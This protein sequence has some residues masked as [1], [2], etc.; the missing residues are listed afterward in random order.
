MKNLYRTIRGLSLAMALLVLSTLH[1]SA[2]TTYSWSTNGS[3]NL[4]GTGTWDL[5][6][7]NWWTNGAPA[8]TWP[9]SGTDNLALFA[10]TAGTVTLGANVAANQLRFLTNG[11]TLSGAQTLTLNGTTPAIQVSGATNNATIGNNTALVLDGTA[12]LKKTGLG[13]LTLNGSAAHAFTGGLNVAQGTL[14]INLANLATPSNLIGS[15]NALTLGGGTLIVNGKTGAVATQTFASTSLNAGTSTIRAIN[16]GTSTTINLGNLTNNEP[17]AVVF[18]NGTGA[19]GTS[20]S[21]TERIFV[22]G[23]PTGAWL[24]PWA[25]TGNAADGTLRWAYL[26]ATS[27]GQVRQQAGITATATTMSNVVTNN[28]VYTATGTFTITNNVSALGIQA[29]G[30][31]TYNLGNFNMTIGGLT[32]LAAVASGT[33]AVQTSGSGQLRG[34]ANGNLITG[35]F[36]NSAINITAPIANYGVGT[37]TSL[38]HIGGGTL[39][40]GAVNPYSGRTTLNGGTLVVGSAST[41][42]SSSG[43]YIN[44]G[45]FRYNNTTTALTP[46]TTLNAGTLTGTGAVTLGAVTVAD[47]LGAIIANNNGAAGAALTT[48]NLSFNGAASL[49]LFLNSTNAALVSGALST[50]SAGQV[51]IT[52]VS[53]TGLWGTGLTY[54]LISYT[55]G[56]VG[57]AGFGQ[58]TLGTV[59]GTTSRQST[60]LGNT[61]L[62]ITMTINGD[63]PYWTG[64][65]NGNWNTTQTGNWKLLTAGTDTT[66]INGDEVIFN[67]NATGTTTVDITENVSTTSVTFSNNTQNYTI[68]SSGGFGITNAV[69]V[70]KNGSGT[71]TLSS[72]NT[73]AGGTAINNGTLRAQGG[74]AIGDTSVVTLADVSAAK[75]EVLNSETIGAL[76]GGGTSGGSV[77]VASGTTLTLSTSTQT[78]A[79][80]I[81]GAG[82]LTVSGTAVQTLTGSNTYTGATLINSGAR[83]NLGNGGT[84]GSLSPIGPITNNGTF[85]INR[86]GTTTQGVDFAN[87]LSGTGTL[88][89]LGG[90][91]VVLATNN[92]YNGTVSITNSAGTTLSLGGLNQTIGALSGG[93]STGGTVALGTNNLTIKALSNQ[94]YN[95]AFTGS[96]N[97][98]IDPGNTN[99]T[100]TFGSSAG[101][102]ST[103][104]TGNVQVR[105][106]TMILGKVNHIL[107]TNNSGLGNQSIFVSN[108]AT[109][110]LAYGNAAYPQYQ[111]FVLN[112]TG[113]NGQGALQALGM[114]FGNAGIGGIVAETDS[115]VRVTRDG[116]DAGTR[117]LLVNNAVA[118]SGNLTFDGGSGTR[119]GIVQLNV[120]SGALTLGGITYNAF[121]GNLTLTGNVTLI[122]NV[123]N[124]L[125]NVQKV[126]VLSGSTNTFNSAANQTI[127]G[128]EGGGTVNINGNTLTVGT[129]DASSTFA[130]VLQN[131]SGSGKLTKTGSGTFTLSASNSY[132]GNTTINGGTLALSGSGTIGSGN[133]VLNTGTLDISGTTTG[134]TIAATNSVTGSGAIVSTG[135]TFTLDGTLAPG[136]SPG[137]ITNTGDFNLGSTANTIME[138]AGSG[139]VAGVDFDY[140]NVTGQLSLGGSLLITNYNSFSL[141]TA[142]TYNLFDATTFSNNFASVAVGAISL[143]NSLGMWTGDNGV[144]TYSFSTLNGDLT[145][146]AVPEPSTCALLGLGALA[147]AY[148]LRRRRRA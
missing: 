14:S 8:T 122:A 67:D 130:G 70:T 24:A 47:N 102:S 58:F 51:V 131:T 5:A 10:G 32:A 88:Q 28:T 33:V 94:T 106:G 111:N 142:G 89:I 26:D 105:S 77:D 124:A 65:A 27:A 37:N 15:G 108:N 93:G 16:T 9:S 31:S 114:N 137:A 136:A 1:L 50:G 46:A 52:P 92:T 132:T 25:F 36:S 129:N 118:G 3:T 127:G 66:F 103:N 6:L 4:G 30:A 29:N 38:T 141:D 104:F 53:S 100:V 34:D 39:T 42:N 64:G 63:S 117:T 125:G 11:Y 79:G 119:P 135:K 21:T 73:Y 44:G 60:L 85:A 75:L 17:G 48:G 146:A 49:N 80:A 133:L 101:A 147:A 20:V 72:S 98:I 91:T 54:N 40:L 123:A 23:A 113:A 43:V 59:A 115:L 148:G 41:I 74:S 116:S 97:I 45:T 128:L 83:L 134:L 107:G 90:G 13:T 18:L 99:A 69:A 62:A 109:V 57:G 140:F 84:T 56:S 68:G 22:S 126:T 120:A 95:G 139:G 112:G 19:F 82:G 145:I 7:P 76:A 61:G 81:T 35:G 2:Q 55:G 110:Q 12:G 71:V 78:Y 87:D 138:L 144:S 86:S 96:G 143:S 121:S